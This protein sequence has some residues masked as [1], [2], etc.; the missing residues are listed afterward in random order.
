MVGDNIP[1]LAVLID[2]ENARS[3][4]V[5]QLLSEIAK[6]GTAHAKRA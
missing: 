2:A 1:K 6:Y 3:S 4:V 5:S